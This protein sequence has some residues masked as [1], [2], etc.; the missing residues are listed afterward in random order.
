[1][2][3]AIEHHLGPGPRR[4]WFALGETGD[5]V[6]LVD[7]S[8]IVGPVPGKRHQ[9]LSWELVYALRAPARAAGTGWYLLAELNGPA[10]TL[11]LCRLDGQHYVE[12]AVAGAGGT[13]T[14]TE[15]FPATLDPTT[16]FS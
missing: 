6:E 13:L 5:R 9:R 11:R 4:T 1:V 10:V 2:T 12:H 3:V 7:G 15:P 8:L 14:L 16:L